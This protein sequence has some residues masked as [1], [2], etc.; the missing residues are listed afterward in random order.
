MYYVFL[1]PLFQFPGEAAG[2]LVH[3]PRYE[4]LDR[5]LES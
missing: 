3:R 2:A 5:S 4:A 1:D